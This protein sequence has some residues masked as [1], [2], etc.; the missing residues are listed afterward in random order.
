MAKRKF[1]RSHI[2]KTRELESIITARLALQSTQNKIYQNFKIQSL[3]L[4]HIKSQKFISVFV[5][6]PPAK[7]RDFINEV[8]GPFN[9]KKTQGYF[10]TLCSESV[11]A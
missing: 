4:Y 11:A 7:Q 9:Y 10:K 6:W 5:S 3:S 1:Y 2:D 8:G